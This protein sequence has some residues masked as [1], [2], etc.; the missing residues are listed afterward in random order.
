MSRTNPYK[1][2][3]RSAN[4]TT[5]IYSEGLNEEIVLKYLRGLYSR[6]KDIAV[7]IRRGKGGTAYGLVIQANKTQGA[8]DRLNSS[9]IHLA[10]NQY[11]YPYYTK[12]RASKIKA[13]VGANKSS[14]QSILIEK[15][16]MNWTNILNY[17]LKVY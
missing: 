11:Y 16:G 2:K 9:S 13:P 14:N 1:K 8:F 17:S 12:D 5:L 3:R 10:L 6:N 15:R 4:K 7:T